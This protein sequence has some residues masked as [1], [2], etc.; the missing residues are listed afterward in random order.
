MS[1]L[2]LGPWRRSYRGAHAEQRSG[3]YDESENSRLPVAD[4]AS[5]MGCRGDM[6][7]T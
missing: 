3:E 7:F 4:F 2:A 6:Y 1:V 5:S